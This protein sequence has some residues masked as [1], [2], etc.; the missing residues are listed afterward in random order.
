MTDSTLGVLA[1]ITSLQELALNDHMDVTDVGLLQLT[2]LTLLDHLRVTGPRGLLAFKEYE[3]MTYLLTTVSAKPLLAV[4]G[5][6]THTAMTQQPVAS[7]A[8]WLPSGLY[9]YM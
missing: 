1:G 8:C 4:G 7:M 6:S 5:I 2:A 3:W 9:K